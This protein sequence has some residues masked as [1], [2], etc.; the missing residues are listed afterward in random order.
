ML[1]AQRG[2]AAFAVVL[3]HLRYFFGDHAAPRGYLAVDFFFMLSG[4][5]MAAAYQDRLDQGWPTLKFMRT[6]MIRLYPLYVTGLSLGLLLLV[7]QIHHGVGSSTYRGAAWFYL[8]GLIFSPSPG[9]AFP[10]DYPLWSLMFEV[11]ANVLHALFLRRRSSRTIAMVTAGACLVLAFDALR[12]G[13]LD[14]GFHTREFVPGLARL[15]FA[16]TVGI[17]IERWRGMQVGTLG[18]LWPAVAAVLLFLPMWKSGESGIYDLAVVSLL[19]PCVL[20]LSAN[21]VLSGRWLGLARRGG[22]LSY[23]CYVLHVPVLAITT[24]LVD[25][26]VARL[27]PTF[28][29]GLIL[30]AASLVVSYGAALA[31]ERVRAYLTA[32]AARRGA[33]AVLPRSA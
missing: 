18:G 24:R 2:V 10:L 11:L 33:S 27:L 29:R 15:T 20:M 32:V 19:F 16:Y 5:V 26:S 7:E 6:R 23:P 12:N 3:L 21:T 4:F 14:R 8:K 9:D 30:L 22:Q 17:L 25:H 1:D 13:T 31:D 28:G